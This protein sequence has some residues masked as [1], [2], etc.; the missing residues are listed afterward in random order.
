MLTSLRTRRPRLLR[1]ALAVTAVLLLGG[2]DSTDTP[3]AQASPSPS[4]SPS[5][6]PLTREE[7]I[8][9]AT[10]LC[11]ARKDAEKAASGPVPSTAAE[12]AA[13]VKRDIESQRE[14]QAKLRA[15]VPPADDREVIER[16]FLDIKEKGIKM[17][18]NALPQ[19]EGIAATGD[20]RGAQT[21]IFP[22]YEEASRLDQSAEPFL[23]S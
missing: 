10:L 20:L 4:P 12:F 6:Q 21:A 16:E 3:N 18:E 19:V 23:S 9:Q 22:I 17:L 2:C 7:Y 15:L 13:A 1:L 5:P 8:N 14:L 11:Q